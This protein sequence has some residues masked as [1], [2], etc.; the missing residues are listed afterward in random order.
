MECA[1]VSARVYAVGN[2]VRVIHSSLVV[3]NEFRCWMLLV[4]SVIP[5]LVDQRVYAIRS[6]SGRAR[7]PWSASEHRRRQNGSGRT[8]AGR[9]CAVREPNP[10]REIRRGHIFTITR[11]AIYNRNQT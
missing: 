3:C 6:A 10:I 8:D 2:T 11:R 4:Q 7:A 9:R 1:V 5:D